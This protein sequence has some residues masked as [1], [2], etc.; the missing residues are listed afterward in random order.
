MTKDIERWKKNSYG[1]TYGHAVKT[2]GYYNYVR[3]RPHTGRLID[4]P[5]NSVARFLT[6]AA[7]NLHACIYEWVKIHIGM[8]ECNG[9]DMECRIWIENKLEV[10]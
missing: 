2:D 5:S 4:G 8:N 1:Y 3:R 9:I 10:K 6:K 7:Y